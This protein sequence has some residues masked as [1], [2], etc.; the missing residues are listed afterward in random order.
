[1]AKRKFT[2]NDKDI[3][4]LELI[5][6]IMQSTYLYSFVF[7]HK[8]EKYLVFWHLDYEKE[9]KIYYPY[10]LPNIMKCIIGIEA[11]YNKEK[12]KAELRSQ[13]NNLLK[14]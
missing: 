6:S 12:G 8:K 2:I 10:T 3:L 4:S 7:E 9:V 14:V 5:I 13:V 1:M 11:L